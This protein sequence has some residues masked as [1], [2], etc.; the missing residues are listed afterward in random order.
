MNSTETSHSRAGWRRHWLPIAGSRKLRGQSLVEFALVLPLLI[1]LMVIAV[2][3]GRIYFSYIQ[4]TNAA[5]EAANYA[6]L[7]PTDTVNIL[8]AAQRETDAQAQTGESAI[9]IPPPICR[10]AAGTVITCATANESGSGAG[11]TITVTV[12]EPFSFLTLFVN[13]FWHNNFQISASATATVFG[14]VASGPG[15]PPGA[16][17]V[18]TASFTVISD[19]TLQISVD[20]SNSSP[21]SGVC[22]ISGYN[23][24]WGD[25]NADVGSA[26][27]STH[28]YASAGTYT[29]ILEV[30]NQGGT[31]TSSHVVTVPTPPPPPT[32]AKPIANFTWTSSGKKRTYTD[33]STVADP[34]NCPITNWLWTFT[35][36][37]TQS[38]A[39]NPAPQTY[40]NNSGHPVTLK[41]TNA[42]GTSSVTYTT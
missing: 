29:V 13:N 30:T 9:Q 1:L 19:S 7:N 41:V 32:C 34:V 25:G 33:T 26:S 5:R 18:P 24:T 12:R 20:P 40:S 6:A 22:N 35:D 23:W 37:G 11:N 17:G 38:N 27:A 4:V 2:D 8:V 10:N 39:Q 3:F 16:C 31:S 15:S 36:L 28:T 42:G 14:F 21:S